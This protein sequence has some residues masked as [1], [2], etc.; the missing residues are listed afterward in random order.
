MAIPT[1]VK[2]LNGMTEPSPY[3]ESGITVDGDNIRVEGSTG[4]T[5][6]QKCQSIA[7]NVQMLTMKKIS[8]NDYQVNI[9]NYQL[10]V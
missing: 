3:K 1:Y 7:E 6:K 5:I 4:A 10:T 8:G 9:G 2:S